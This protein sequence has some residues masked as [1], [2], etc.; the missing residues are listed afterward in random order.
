VIGVV[1][2]LQSNASYEGHTGPLPPS[3]PPSAAPPPQTPPSSPQTPDS[4]EV[5]NV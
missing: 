4:G 3:V 5:K 2:L 1:K